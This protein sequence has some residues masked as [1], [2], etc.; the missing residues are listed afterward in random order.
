MPLVTITVHKPRSN[1]L[2]TAVLESVHSALVSTGVDP[3]NVI[4]VFEE[5]SWKSWSF[6]GGRL[7]HA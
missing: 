3:E 1:A 7:L 6:G 2:E 4:V 5:T